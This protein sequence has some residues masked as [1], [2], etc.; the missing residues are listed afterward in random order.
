MYLNGRNGEIGSNIKSQSITGVRWSGI[1]QAGR[2]IAQLITTIVLARLLAPSEFGLISMAIVVI[3]FISIFK[4][5]GTSAAVIQ[6]RELSDEL[7]SS[8]F[9]INTGFGT[10]SMLLVFLGAPLG[11][12]LYNNPQVT[13]V[14]QALS[15]GFFISGFTILHQALLERSL[16]FGTL[17]KIELA[18]VL[19][20]SI[21]GIV[22]ALLGA[23]VWSLV[24][25]ILTNVTMTTVL[26]W[27]STSWRPRLV[28][29]WNEVKSIKNYS[30]NL[31]GFAVFNY[32]ARNADYLLIGRYLGAQDLGYYTLAY[33]ILLFPVKNISKVISRVMFPVYSNLQD[34]N[35]RLANI[36]LKVSSTIALITFPLMAGVFTLSKPFIVSLFGTK[37]EP[38]ILLI[39]ILS[40]VGLIQSIGT[41][42]GAIYQAK[43]RTDIMFRW[44]LVTET[45][46]IISFIVGLRWGVIGV[47]IAYA[48]VSFALFYPSFYIVFRLI[49]LK[50]SNL[51]DYLYKPFLNSVVMSLLIVLFGLLIS[52]FVSDYLYLFLAVLFGITIYTLMSYLFNRDYLYAFFEILGIKAKEG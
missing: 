20:G 50:V 8:I 37:W 52:K 40:P 28:F 12:M 23:G 26:L 17:A 7:L 45:C 47:A 4:D 30:L 33:R 9:W 15:L 32:F 42:V 14:L 49:N 35:Q 27:F 46:A 18:A 19:S 3:G 43:G 51:I 10:F 22:L 38:V 1:A 41:T 44:G 24:M 48:I 11:A 29:N 31:T 34:D 16:S 36:Y 13:P 5:L 25:Q 39:M 2:Q 6:R 21:A